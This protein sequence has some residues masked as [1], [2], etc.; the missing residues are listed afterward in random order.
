M[1]A[2]GFCPYSIV[3]DSGNKE[4]LGRINVVTR[5]VSFKEGERFEQIRYYCNDKEIAME[6]YD[7]NGI[8]LY[9]TGII[10]DGIVREYYRIGVLKKE[11]T[12][13]DGRAHG[14]GIDYYPSG[15]IF[16]ESTFMQGHLHGPNRMYRR[17]GAPW[18]E[19]NYKDGKLHGTFTSYHDNGNT[20]TRAEYNDGKLNGSYKKYDIYSNLLEEGT[21]NQGEQQGDHRYYHVTGQLARIERYS[22][23]KL[24]CLKE[25][26]EEG[27]ATIV[28]ECR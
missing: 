5:V 10:P 23:G 7:K 17:D 21:F 28:T 26:D 20:E 3:M 16:E 15:E 24:I 9:A 12:F 4:I 11:I 8:L 2:F 14:R 13:K 19:A 18:I 22:R 1:F 6:V 25:F 27:R